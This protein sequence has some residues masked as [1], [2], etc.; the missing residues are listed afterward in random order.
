M[1]HI[2]RVAAIGVVLA[3]GSVAVAANASATGGPRTLTLAVHETT[4]H[5]SDAAPTKQLSAGD[6]F[7]IT[8][9]LAQSGKTVGNDALNC[10]QVDSAENICTGT[11]TLPGR[12]SV[13]IQGLSRTTT[14]SDT[15]T[16]VG[17]TGEFAG[18]GGILTTSGDSSTAQGGTATLRFS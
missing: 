11:F 16:I 6:S 13:Q 1:K 5:Y 4:F 18:A 15:Y 8:D 2:M 10:V 14:D 7:Q 17:G 3:G 12:G 9:R